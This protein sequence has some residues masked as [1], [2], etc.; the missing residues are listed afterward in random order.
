[1]DED[2]GTLSNATADHPLRMSGRSAFYSFS[3]DL[4]ADLDFIGLA[5]RLLRSDMATVAGS[6]SR[7]GLRVGRRV[8]K[9]DRFHRRAQKSADFFNTVY[10]GDF[11]IR[12]LWQADRI[13]TLKTAWKLKHVIFPVI[14]WRILFGESHAIKTQT[15]SQQ[16]EGNSPSEKS[17]E[18]LNTAVAGIRDTF[19]DQLILGGMRLR[20]EQQVYFP[21]Y[22]AQIEPFIRL[23][24]NR[25]YFTGGPFENEPIETSLMIHRSGICILTFAT[26]VADELDVDTAH[27]TLLSSEREFDQVKLAVPI[28]SH[29]GTF[30]E[31]QNATIHL[32]DEVHEGLKWV[33]LSVAESSDEQ[34]SSLKLTL[35]S[36]F[37][38]YLNTIESAA[39]RKIRYEWRCYTTLF[40]GKP[41]CGC[42]GVEAKRTHGVDF[43][44]LLVRSR[45]PY[46][47]MDDVREELL[48]NHLVTTHAELWL[49]A[50]CA[51]YAYW[52]SDD[53]DYPAD[54]EALE[55]IEFAILQYSQLEAVDTRTVNV[56]VKDR[57]LFDAQ[58]QIATNMPEYGRNLMSDINAPRVVT[59]LSLLLNTQQV[60]NRITDRVKILESIVNTRFTRRQSLRSLAISSIGLLVVLLLLLPRIEEFTAKLATLT[61]TSGLMLALNQFFRTQDRATVA[62]Y[63]IAL[64][65]T[66]TIFVAFTFRVPR[67]SLRRR[68]RNFGYPTK[69]D[70]TVRREKD[71][72]PSSDSSDEAE[73]A[74]SPKVEN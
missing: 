14:A 61:P 71:R 40:L 9:T 32:E 37:Y 5:N 67:G 19:M 25:S 46:P 74:A 53:V 58:K 42:T 70:V 16:H 8:A 10:S 11:S 26:P 52:L 69:H 45:S 22:Y 50:G 20:L 63:G 73:G 28:F 49:S 36:V 18:T 72:P 41:V 64:A 66:A 27:R 24:M 3:F 51:I 6:P 2:Q 15:E 62:I 57:N 35:M 56:S 47:V 59:D 23:E 30:P 65:A 60:S 4:G 68:R 21:R 44:Q 55:P 39:R 48:K 31:V 54:L 1:M 33:S 29:K 7:D 12:R 34:E 13:T 43:G 38:F 17:R